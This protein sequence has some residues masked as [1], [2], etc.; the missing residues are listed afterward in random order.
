MMNRKPFSLLVGVLF[1]FSML[2]CS[3]A[4]A[5]VFG[6]EYVAYTMETSVTYDSVAGR[7]G[8]NSAISQNSTQKMGGLYSAYGLGGGKRPNN[9]L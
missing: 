2:L 8:V 1:L 3:S 4:Y 9:Q 7:H 5:V 6:N